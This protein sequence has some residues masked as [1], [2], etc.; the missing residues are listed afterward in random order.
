MM[1]IATEF[2]PTFRRVGRVLPSFAVLSAS[3][4]MIGHYGFGVP[5]NELAVAVAVPLVGIFAISRMMVIALPAVPKS[6]PSNRPGPPMVFMVLAMAVFCAGVAAIDFAFSAVVFSQ[7]QIPDLIN[8]AW[9]IAAVCGIIAGAAFVTAVLFLMR[10]VMSSWWDVLIAQ[11]WQILSC[12]RRFA[13]G[14][15]LHS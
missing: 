9:R 10:T 14:M 2:A 5:L 4:C 8:G 1:N 7:L 13:D 12:P 3:G 6:E 11:I 15:H